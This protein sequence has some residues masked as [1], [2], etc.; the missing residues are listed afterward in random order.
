MEH[1]LSTAQKWCSRAALHVRTCRSEAGAEAHKSE[2]A[3][4][5]SVELVIFYPAIF[6]KAYKHTVVAIPLPW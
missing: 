2:R 5:H 6:S 3:P 1:R 4:Q